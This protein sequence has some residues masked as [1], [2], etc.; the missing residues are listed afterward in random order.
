MLQ[1]VQLSKHI[2]IRSQDTLP[3]CWD[4]NQP[5]NLNN[6]T[7]FTVAIASVYAAGTAAAAI[8]AIAA[9][10]AAVALYIGFQILVSTPRKPSRSTQG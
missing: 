5:A 7:S 3:G 1:N 2:R 8:A 4:V 10:T 6:V 9:T